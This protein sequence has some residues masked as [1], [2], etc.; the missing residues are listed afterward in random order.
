MG[1]DLIELRMRDE[2]GISP[3]V[4]TNNELPYSFLASNWDP[5]FQNIPTAPRVPVYIFIAGWFKQ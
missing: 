2:V 5:N 3:S 4:P 1:K